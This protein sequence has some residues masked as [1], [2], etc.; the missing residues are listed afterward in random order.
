MTSNLQQRRLSP[1][2]F[3]PPDRKRLDLLADV[4]N[5]VHPPAVLGETG[6]E[7]EIPESVYRVFREIIN[8]MREGK[9]ILLIPEHEVLTTQAAADFLGVSRP[10]FVSLL[11][12]NEIPHHVVGSHRRVH[13]SDVNEYRKKR[14][15]ERHEGLNRL[16]KLIS[17][18]GLYDAE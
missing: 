1:E 18:A 4:M 17:D 3:S 7:L 10:H 12:Q 11:D 2:G 13:F 9:S 14:D 8:Q 15:R 16:T 5:R 6:E